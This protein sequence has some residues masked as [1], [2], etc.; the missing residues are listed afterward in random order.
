MIGR[1]APSCGRPERR[2]PRI[3]AGRPGG[4]PLGAFEVEAGEV[5]CISESLTIG[6]LRARRLR[7]VG[8]QRSEG[9]A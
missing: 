9:R 3:W 2:A 5:D 4:G 8:K 7:R 1:G 6:G